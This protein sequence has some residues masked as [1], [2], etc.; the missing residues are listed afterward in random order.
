MTKSGF[1][2][3]G[4]SILDRGIKLAIWGFDLVN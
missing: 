3:F 1:R 4:F 2:N